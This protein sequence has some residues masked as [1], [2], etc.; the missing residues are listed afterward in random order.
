MKLEDPVGFAASFASKLHADQGKTY[1]KDADGAP[2]PYGKHLRDAYL[3]ALRFGHTD[4]KIHT[5]LFL[6]DLVEDLFKDESRE[7]GY[8]I[9]RLLFGPEVHD[10]VFAVTDEPGKNRKERKA[11][12]YPKIRA[13]PKAVIVKL[14]DRIANLEQAHAAKNLGM[15]LM[16]SGEQYEFRK[17]LYVPGENEAMWA[18]IDTLFATRPELP[19]P[20]PVAPEI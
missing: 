12:T 11:A 16:Y 9:V 17:A 13:L 20:V 3:V 19:A 7:Q 10:I 4:K 18:H 2:M 15:W 6:H 5:A 8:Q 1:G 14:C